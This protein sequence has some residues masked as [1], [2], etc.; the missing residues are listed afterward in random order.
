VAA[1]VIERSQIQNLNRRDQIGFSDLQA[2]ANEALRIAG[3]AALFSL[4]IMHGVGSL[5]GAPVK[6]SVSGN[7]KLR[8]LP[9]RSPSDI[10]WSTAKKNTASK[11]GRHPVAWSTAA[12]PLDAGVVR[13]S[14]AGR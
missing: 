6:D 13:T 10:S 8:G 12:P 4:Q 7:D 11:G 14:P 3:I 9:S 5:A 2:P 1:N